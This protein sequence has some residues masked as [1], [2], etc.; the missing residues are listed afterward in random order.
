MNFLDVQV[1]RKDNQIVTDLYT[2]PTDTHQ[3]LYRSSC[4]PNHTKKRIPYGQALCTR[5]IC[6]DDSCFERHLGNL[7]KFLLDRGY[8]KGETQG[9]F[10]RV[11]GLDRNNHLTRNQKTE[12]IRQYPWF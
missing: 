9:Q 3:L 2:K 11:K 4:H 8:D 7:E 10:N 1:I 12:M 5:C 6:S